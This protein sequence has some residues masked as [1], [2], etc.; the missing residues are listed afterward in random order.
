VPVA[1]PSNPAEGV[2]PDWREAPFLTRNKRFTVCYIGVQI[3][4]SEDRGRRRGPQT[5]GRRS[6]R[7][8]DR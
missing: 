4:A 5:S 6:P 1:L 7:R 8:R 2:M 3:P